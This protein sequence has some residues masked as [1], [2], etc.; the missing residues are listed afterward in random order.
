MTDTE[1]TERPPLQPAD[2]KML[3]PWKDNT[4]LRRGLMRMADLASALLKIERAFDDEDIDVDYSSRWSFEKPYAHINCDEEEKARRVVGKLIR[5]LKMNPKMKKVADDAINAVFELE[6]AEIVVVGYK[7]KTCRYEEIEVS[8]PAEPERIETTVH[9]A[10][11]AR[12]EK[13][14][15]LVCDDA[16]PETQEPEEVA[17]AAGDNNEVPF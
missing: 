10:K 3:S 14:R 4:A 11:P 16:T 6:G 8:L 2:G 13:R 17:A 15:V 9:D 5:A 7:P 12:I 1:L